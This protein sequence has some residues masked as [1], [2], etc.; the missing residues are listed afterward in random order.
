MFSVVAWMFDDLQILSNTTKHDRTHT[1]TIKQHQTR[2]PN[3]KMFGHQ[4]TFDGV[5]SPNIY[6][7]SRSLRPVQKGNVWW[8]NVIKHCLVT[9]HF[10]VCRATLFVAVWSCLI[11]LKAIKHSRNNLKHFFCSRVWWAMSVV[12]LDMRTTGMPTTLAQPRVFIVWSL[13]DQAC[14]NRLA[15]HFNISML[16]RQTLPVWSGLWTNGD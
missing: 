6:R 7:L 10:T 12:R 16:G 11:N 3:G 14:F 5:W 8:P 9:K 2:C 4:T 1:N 13:F 15:T